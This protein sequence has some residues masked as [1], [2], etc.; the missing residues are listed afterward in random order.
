[1]GRMSVVPET[2]SQGP[3]PES[4]Q[5]NDTVFFQIKDQGYQDFVSVEPLG[6][7]VTANAR[8]SAIDSVMLRAWRRGVQGETTGIGELLSLQGGPVKDAEIK[9]QVQ[10]LL[11]QE[12]SSTTF[13]AAGTGF[14]D[15]SSDL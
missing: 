8:D 1:M 10:T 7:T 12:G 2:D 5:C 14:S 15:N 9:R 13:S 6:G 3:W 4:S 11:E